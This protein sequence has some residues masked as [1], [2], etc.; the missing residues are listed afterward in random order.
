M[1]E[2]ADRMPRKSSSASSCELSESPASDM[3]DDDD[4][5]IL[6]VMVPPPVVTVP[7]VPASRRLRGGGF[8]GGASDAGASVFA[9]LDRK[10]A[11]CW[12]S[13]CGSVEEIT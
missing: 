2:G 10:G 4:D 1:E 8:G 13:R 3:E 7:I 6:S 12:E 5:G 9:V 11:R